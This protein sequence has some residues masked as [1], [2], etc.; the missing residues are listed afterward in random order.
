MAGKP[1]FR[2]HG[3]WRRPDAAALTAFDEASPAQIADAM[4]RM[5]SM[6]AGITPVWRS[7]RIIGSALTVW[8]HTGDNLMVHKAMSMAVPG[9]ILVWNTQGNRLNSGF[10]ELL[11]TSAVKIG[12]RGIIVDGTVRDAEA[13]EAMRLPVYSR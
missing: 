10:G 7:P 13:L 9:D 11:A 5:G 4:S 3:P 8:T 2:V 1:G 12:I 6:D